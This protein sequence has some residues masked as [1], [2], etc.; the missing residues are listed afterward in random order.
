VNAQPILVVEHE[1]QC[2]PGWMGDW[3]SEAGFELDVR[4]PYLTDALPADLSEHRS[5]VVLGGA[6]NAY[7]DAVHPWLTDVKS[8][9]RSAVDDGTPTLGICLGLQLMTVALG[10]EV[11]RNPHGQQIGV[12]AVGWLPAAHDDALFGPL[13]GAR[14]AVQWND[15]V[16][17]DLPATSVVLARTPRQEI[18]AVRFAPTMWG[19]Q[20]HPEAGVD[21]IAGWAEHDRDDAWERGIDIDEYVA[22]V[23]AAGDELQATWRPLAHGFAAMSRATV[24]AS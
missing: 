9:L 15:D 10:G 4:R 16:V 17:R 18:Q 11:H 8:L 3:L 1:A 5:M 14:I 24:A 19:V 21:I 23:A 12:P 2:P 22:H 7:A 6:T 20:W 13:T